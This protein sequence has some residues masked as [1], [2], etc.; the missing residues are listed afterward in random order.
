[1][2]PAGVIS[3]V[4]AVERKIYLDQT[5][6]QIK[7]APEYDE[8]TRDKPDYRDTLGTYYGGNYGQDTA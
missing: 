7:N 8:E 2:L 4:D 3:R 5:K 6:E 1:L